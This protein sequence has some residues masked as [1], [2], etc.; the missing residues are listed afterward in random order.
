MTSKSI[1]ATIPTNPINT[2]MVNIWVRRK[3]K[4]Y[5]V[6]IPTVRK[7]WKRNGC[8]SREIVNTMI[9]KILLI[10]DKT[11]NGTEKNE[12]SKKLRTLTPIIV[13]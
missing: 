9:E 1:I 13:P 7:L 6:N 3:K 11:N 4:I 5:P 12:V 2:G 10:T 8:S